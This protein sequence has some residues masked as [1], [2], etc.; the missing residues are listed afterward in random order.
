[1]LLSSGESMLAI[2]NDILDF[3]KIEA[4]HLDVESV[5][6]DLR[7]TIQETHDLLAT[8]AAAKGL[9]L[10][11]QYPDDRPDW[12]LG[13]PTR[14]RQ[15]VM[16]LIGN[17][18][19]FTATGS[20]TVATRIDPGPQGRWNLRLAVADTGIGIPAS[21]Q[22]TL[23]RRFTQV[24][25]ST[26]RKFGGTG[27]G[28]AISKQ[29]VALMGG[30]MGL[31][32]AEGVGSTFWFELPLAINGVLPAATT[33]APAATTATVA[34]FGGT[35]VLLVDDNPVNLKVAGRMLEKM[36]CAVVTALNGI[37]AIDRIGQERFD[38]VFMDC[39]MPEMDG[40]AATT[41]LRQTG[42]RTPIV[43]MT[44]N[45]LVGDRN[46]CLAAGMDD[47]VA[48]PIKLDALRETLTRWAPAIPATTP[49]AK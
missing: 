34:E 16:N 29:L 13:D 31:E 33:P 23:F 4:G 49:A 39:Q 8:K 3:S 32:S 2:L 35:R 14:I 30:T 25:S 43:A 9:V 10:S 46:I 6:F 47:Y 22:P 24:D 36:G 18:I 7:R 5:P 21:A 27:L 38:V 26:T 42:V 19:K 12:F 20:V 48:K 1:M 44:A 17:A 11:H 45:A 41:R 40:Y 15:V 37:E 28:L